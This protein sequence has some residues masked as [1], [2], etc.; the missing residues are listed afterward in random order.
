MYGE[1]SESRGRRRQRHGRL[2]A[3]A[4]SADVILLQEMRL[5]VG[6]HLDRL[7]PNHILFYNTREEDEEGKPGTVT[8]VKRTWLR[9][10]DIVYTIIDAG[11]S[12]VLTVLAGGR[13]VWTLVNVYLDSESW[14]WE[15]KQN[16]LLGMSPLL[17]GRILLGGDWNF[18]ETR[19]ALSHRAILR[20]FLSFWELWKRSHALWEP[21]QPEWTY[22]RGSS[23]LGR[24]QSR[25][26]RFY[27]NLREV[28]L[29]G[30]EIRTWAAREMGGSDH[31]PVFLSILCYPV[32]RQ[33]FPRL[34]K[35]AARDPRFREDLAGRWDVAQAVPKAAREPTVT[36]L[37]RFHKCAREALR[38]LKATNDLLPL[39]MMSFAQAGL[40]VLRAVREGR[41]FR[42]I[43]SRTRALVRVVLDARWDTRMLVIITRYDALATVMGRS[44]S[45]VSGT[46]SPPSGWLV[47]PRSR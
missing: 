37:Y 36:H 18:S 16:S 11:A 1:C 6:R 22:C 19:D 45:W 10:R 14:S 8:M 43:L 12:S 28:D 30:G 29:T 23:V 20:D 24:V 25:L 34:H 39:S 33:N 3:C 2:M 9:A 27:T 32:A 7:F 40:G 31:R 44:P 21:P 41:P 13:T 15:A 42:T 47:L 4:R 26:D 5:R 38:S 17:Q 46:R 35:R